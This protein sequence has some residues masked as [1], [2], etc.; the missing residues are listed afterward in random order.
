MKLNLCRHPSMKTLLISCR[1][2]YE[3]YKNTREV[4]II[5]FSVTLPKNSSA[6]PLDGDVH[7]RGSSRCCCCYPS[8]TSE[9]RTLYSIEEMLTVLHCTSNY[10]ASF[11]MSTFV[12]CPLWLMQL[13][14]RWLFRPHFRCRSSTA[15]VARGATALKTFLL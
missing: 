8:R 14:C 3:T 9:V 6:N 13:R 1:F 7:T 4:P 15:A 2:G 12:P 11:L 10:P 5:P